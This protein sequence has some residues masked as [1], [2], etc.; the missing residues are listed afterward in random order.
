MPR[1]CANAPLGGTALAEPGGAPGSV[2]DIHEHYKGNTMNKTL[3]TLLATTAAS[4]CIGAHA[5]EAAASAPLLDHAEAKDLKNQSD[6]HYKAHK[7]EADARLDLNKAD[8]KSELK[9]AVA[10]ACK[11][12]AKAQARKEKADAKLVNKAEKADVDGAA[13]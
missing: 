5:A 7:K 12:D 9:G 1:G 8:C 13:K 3:A 6:A 4:L 10:R 11:D 2:P